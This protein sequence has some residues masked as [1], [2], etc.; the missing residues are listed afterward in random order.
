M[1]NKRQQAIIIECKLNGGTITTAEC[2]DL[3]KGEYY[4]NH[5]HYVSEILSR[6]VKS[7]ILIR[8]SRGAYKLASGVKGEKEIEIPN[9]L[10]LF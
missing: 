4:C 5:E 9:Q 7:N 8:T 3:L 6:M 10:N 1:S 2:N